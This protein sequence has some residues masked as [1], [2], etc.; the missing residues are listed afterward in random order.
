MSH[1][2][3]MEMKARSTNL[4]PI[5]DYLEKSCTLYKGVDLQT[6]TYFNS[7]SGRLKLREGNIENALIY[8]NRNND[9]NTK[10]S[11]IT[12]SKQAPNNGIKEILAT[13][14]GVKVVVKKS[15]EIY[16]INNIKF[17]LD[18]VDG[19][20]TFVEIEAIDTDGTFKPADLKQQ[21]DFYT[22]TFNIKTE[23]L[24]SYSYSDLILEKMQQL[25]SN[26]QEEFKNFMTKIRSNLRDLKLVVEDKSIDHAC[27]RVA[28]EAGYQKQKSNL[29]LLGELLAESLIG[30]RKIS[31]YK[32]YQP[33]VDDSGASISVLELPSPKKNNHYADGFE[34]IEVVMEK[35]FKDF[36]K[37]YP[38]IIFD[39]SGADKKINPELRIKFDDNYSVKFHHQ[40][41]QEIIKNEL[42]TNN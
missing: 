10:L 39:W 30:G 7:K 25:Q 19:L 26:L 15:R 2:I 40:T 5:R 23:E 13:T 21:C 29:S 18:H 1:F 32:L 34:H 12:L 14:N 11:D 41:L 4:D 28:S 31:T 20:G 6:D 42:L 27:Y 9:Q 17:H 38:N 22:K 24:I 3:N 35:S 16:F 33:L 37:L 8:Y 36:S